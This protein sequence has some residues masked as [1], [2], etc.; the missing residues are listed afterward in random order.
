MLSNA[1]PR[2]WKHSSVRKEG[3]ALWYNYESNLHIYQLG[4]RKNTQSSFLTKVVSYETYDII[5]KFNKP[6][7]NAWNCIALL[8]S[9]G[10]QVAR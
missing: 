2:L 10:L 1:N 6:C 4:L 9:P 5:F 7:N 8:I 3:K